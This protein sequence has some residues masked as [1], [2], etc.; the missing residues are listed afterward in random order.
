MS[1]RNNAPLLQM[2]GVA[3]SFANFYRKHDP[4]A[5]WAGVAGVIL[6]CRMFIAGFYSARF[7][8]VKENL[9]RQKREVAE[10]F[11]QAKGTLPELKARYIKLSIADAGWQL[12]VWFSQKRQ[13]VTESKAPVVPPKNTGSFFNIF[14]QSRQPGTAPAAQH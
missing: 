10:N 13:N 9:D 3:V 11:A 12:G 14:C 7:P 6:G 2:I 4:I 8:K 1:G 5:F